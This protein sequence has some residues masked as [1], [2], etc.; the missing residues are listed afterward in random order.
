MPHVDVDVDEREKWQVGDQKR[1]EMRATT[2]LKEFDLVETL[3]SKME[4]IQRRRS[5]Q[6]SKL[7]KKTLKGRRDAQ[8]RQRKKNEIKVKVMKLEAN[9]LAK[10]VQTSVMSFHS[11][12]VE[13]EKGNPVAESKSFGVLKKVI[14]ALPMTHIRPKC[15]AKQPRS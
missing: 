5:L 15:S 8:K 3:D 1:T 14:I 2:A 10:E 9:L 11:E 6:F 13:D 7:K 4:G 12:K